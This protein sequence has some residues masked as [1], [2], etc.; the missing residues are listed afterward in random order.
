MAKTKQSKPKPKPIQVQPLTDYPI[1][2]IN[3]DRLQFDPANPNQ[4]TSQQEHGLRRSI[5]K[6]G[7]LVP[8]IVT[9]DYMIAD[10]EHRARIYK[11][12]GYKE[13]P[14]FVVDK[15]VTDEDRK[16][17]RQTMNK[18]HGKHDLEM[19]IQEL[20]GLYEYDAHSLQTILAIDQNAMNDLKD[21]LEQ[22]KPI[23]SSYG[24]TQIDDKRVED[25]NPIGR[26]ADTY[27]HGNVKQITLIFSNDEFS[28]LMP[29]LQQ[30][31]KR[32][33]VENNT[34]LF[35]KMVASFMNEGQ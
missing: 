33:S 5:E 31:Y 17:L 16:L 28:D 34:D 8:I 18:L 13:I 21:I 35:L 32:F 12:M 3:I 25:F 15:L 27:L 6:F 24:V 23:K 26:H 9:K 7:Y 10:G 22:E 30:L 11:D 14:A 29:K 2:N 4:L 20:K 1:K 19:D